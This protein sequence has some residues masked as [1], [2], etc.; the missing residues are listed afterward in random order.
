MSGIV[1]TYLSILLF[2]SN[3]LLSET[4]ERITKD[5]LFVMF[6]EVCTTT[7]SLFPLSML[8]F[9]CF[10]ILNIIHIFAYFTP[11]LMSS[12]KSQ[13]VR[14]GMSTKLRLDD[15]L[16]K[17]IQRICKYPLLFRELSRHTPDQDTDQP[18]FKELV[19]T[20]DGIVQHVN[21]ARKQFEAVKRV[22][23]VE[24]MLCDLPEPLVASGRVLVKEG[25]LQKQ[26]PREGSFRQERYCFLFR[27]PVR[28][29][30]LVYTKMKNKKSYIFR[31]QIDLSTS[32]ITTFLTSPQFLT[33]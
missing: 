19:R 22:I 14:M 30:I 32:C 16:I 23:E 4:P 31:G 15:Y 12:H 33:S 5:P 10:L 25:V 27:G 7:K 17:P 20:L 2:M 26:S 11:T 21:D 6:L 3:F 18:M 29:D 13:R 28:Q 24:N 1:F 8:S 9:I